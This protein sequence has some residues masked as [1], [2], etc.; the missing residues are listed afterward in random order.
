MAYA[1]WTRETVKELIEQEFSIVI[2]IRT[3]GK[4]LSL[5]GFTPQKPL[6]KAYEQSPE[7]ITQWLEE[8][9]PGIKVRAKAEKTEIYWGGETGM[10]NDSQQERGY[11]P[12]GQVPVIRLDAKRVSINMLS[13]I[14]NRGKVSFKLFEGSMT[15]D[16]LIDFMRRLIKG[17]KRKVFLILDNPSACHAQLVKAWLKEH[18]EEIEVFYLPACSPGLNPDEYLN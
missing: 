11:A 16:I 18:P 3:V 1:L 12:K 7:K 5:W 15:A 4:Y 8:T 9:Y 10:R 6:M 17:A 13:A 14:T 2:A